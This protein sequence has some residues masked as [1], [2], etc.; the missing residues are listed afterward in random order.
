MSPVSALTMSMMNDIGAVNAACVAADFTVN[1]IRGTREDEDHWYG[2][3]F[4]PQIPTL[5]EMLKES[6]EEASEE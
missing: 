1:C 2:V 5:I 4:E 3:K 6:E